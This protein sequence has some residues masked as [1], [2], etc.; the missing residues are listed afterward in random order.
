MSTAFSD[1][2]SPISAAGWKQKI[3]FELNGA[4]YQTLLTK[5]PEGITIKPFYHSDE[6]EKIVVPNQTKKAV[7][8]Q[9]IEVNSETEANKIALKAFETGRK[10]IQF[11]IYKPIDLNSLFANLLHKNIDFQLEF[12]PISAQFIVECIHFL[13]DENAHFYIDVLGNLCKTGN[14]AASQTDDLNVLN[15]L[16]IRFS[17]LHIVINAALYQ[18][19]GATITQQ[20]AYTLAHY[21]EYLHQ[22]GG[23]IGNRIKINFAIG[24]HFFF[25][26]SKIRAFR[27][28][29]NLLTKE[30]NNLTAILEI[31]AL[32][33]LR[34]K[35][36][37][38]L[39]IN[40]LRIK[41]ELMSAVLGGVDSISTSTVLPEFQKPTKEM[42]SICN[43]TYYIESITK[44]LA[45]KAL[46]IF[47]EIEKGGGFIQQLKEGTIQRKINESAKKEQEQY[48]TNTFKLIGGNIYFEGG[49]DANLSPHFTKKEYRKTLVTPITTK[50]LSIKTE[51]KRI[52]NE[53]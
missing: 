5:T 45:E 9:T 15:K 26:I 32:P 38:G 14:W 4:D 16:L 53:T 28:L 52:Q 3:Q 8:F 39:E 1:D 6:F 11:K 46:I 29:F 10:S 20:L 12:T 49:I 40:T 47:K 7:Y 31:N 33:S 18:N 37:F 22:F 35:T 24:S 48:D 17:N 30:Y 27:Y 2:F 42:A 41:T 34:N 50:R 44:Q 19:A 51:Q 13:K 43:E 25:E 23:N 21:N 36:Y